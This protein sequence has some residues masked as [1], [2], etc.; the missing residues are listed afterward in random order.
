M[1]MVTDEEIK[2]ILFK[3]KEDKA[4]RPDGFSAG[5]FQKL[6]HIVG[7]DV[8][9]AI[10]SFF[11]SEK[12]LKEFNNTAITLIPKINSPSKLS[13]YRPISCCNTVYKCI[14]GILA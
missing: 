1:S 5:F 9:A 14:S 6:W 4:P 7:V 11:E 12:L 10:K 8:C 3:M 2:A 13:D